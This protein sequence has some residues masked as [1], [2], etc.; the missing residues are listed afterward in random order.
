M[1]LLHCIFR[2]YP[3]EEEFLEVV[4]KVKR[5]DI[6]GCVGHPGMMVHLLIMNNNFIEGI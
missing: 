6:I 3:S 1:L 2:F 4:D 5:G